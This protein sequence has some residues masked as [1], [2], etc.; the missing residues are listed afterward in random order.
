MMKGTDVR[1]QTGKSGHPRNETIRTIQDLA[2]IKASYRRMVDRY[3]YQL[4][5]CAGAGCI[6]SDCG[7]VKKAATE[8]IARLG[9]SDQVLI[10]E[11]GC[12]G[13]CAVGPVMLILPDR[14]FYTELTPATT[15]EIIRS[16]IVSG[17]IAEEHTF[18][19]HS[20]N[21]RIPCIDDIDFFR[22]QDRKSVV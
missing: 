21:R 20:L 15:V 6:S 9:L 12:M 1:K 13:T 5:I 4:L 3:P 16:H 19:D 10:H 8:E 2:R 22:D 17:R 18:F 7:K 11:T 14:T